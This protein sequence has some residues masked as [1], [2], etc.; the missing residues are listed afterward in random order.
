MAP[1]DSILTEYRGFGGAAREIGQQ[2]QRLAQTRNTNKRKSGNVWRGN[3][4]RRARAC[5]FRELRGDWGLVW[6]GMGCV[7]RIGECEG[8]GWRLE[9]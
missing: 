6:L 9:D 1:V 7:K 8:L 2:E 4:R 5:R 3:Y